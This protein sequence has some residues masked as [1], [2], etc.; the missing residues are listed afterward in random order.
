MR[1]HCK[2]TG[3]WLT[4]AMVGWVAA[5]TSA[6]VPPSPPP[7][8]ASAPFVVAPA[9]SVATLRAVAYV[10]LP[11]EAIPTGVT[12]TIRNVR[13]GSSATVAFVGGGFDPVALSAVVGDTI[14][15]AVQTTGS[16]IAFQFTVP[17]TNPPVI[18]RT[19][20][21]PHKRD[22]PLNARMTIVFSEPIDAATLTSSSLQLWAG[23]TLVDGQRTFGDS[24]HTS[25][26]FVPTAPLAGATDY[27]LIVT[28]G[29]RDVNG[30]ALAAPITVP[31]TT[32]QVTSAG[33]A[34]ASVTISPLAVTIPVGTS[35]SL[36]ATT[37]DSVGSV[38]SGR[39]VVWTS[40]APAIATVSQTGVVT[41]VAPGGP[42]TI[43]A[44]SEGRRATATITVLAITA[45][46]SQIAFVD[47]GG[48]GGRM[49]YV[50]N[51]DG[52]GRRVLTRS[53]SDVN[54]QSYEGWSRLAWS[55]DSKRLA[56]ES[57]GTLFGVNADGSGLG[58]LAGQP[59]ST[60]SENGAQAWS[61]DGTTIAFASFI[62]YWADQGTGIN[63]AN[64]YDLFQTGGVLASA[65]RL[66]TGNDWWP[67]WSPDGKQIAFARFDKAYFLN[68]GTAAGADIYVMNADGSGIRRLTNQ[69]WPVSGLTWSPDGTKITFGADTGGCQSILVMNP[70]GSG[71]TRLT[72]CGGVD[73]NPSWSPDGTKIV[74]ERNRDIYTMNADGSGITRLTFDGHAVDPA[75]A[76]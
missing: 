54:S 7:P 60:D 69:G 22:V 34:V 74:F 63:L 5:C 20:P 44:T 75:W 24:A 56:F 3:L 25:V 38:L 55:P 57:G 53:V 71:I 15:V 49:I 23:S 51:P 8:I 13:T 9:A 11:P 64:P 26:Q 48:I 61:P 14:A 58:M 2:V 28:P 37:K 29:I 19:E 16:P 4:V 43:T 36:T 41:G 66:T 12:A 65:T 59:G 32:G 6:T 70:D 45:G 76:H 46:M 68:P 35:A 30:A 72:T 33:A 62:W 67:S 73:R 1:I 52:T 31:F 21:P 18:V 39:G 40:S 42:V 10:S 17:A 47:A 27:Q 50:M